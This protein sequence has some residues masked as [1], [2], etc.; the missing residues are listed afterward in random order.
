MTAVRHDDDDDD[1]IVSKDNNGKLDDY[2]GDFIFCAG[3]N[4]H[5]IRRKTETAGD[6]TSS[7]RTCKQLYY[8]HAC[9]G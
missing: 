9:R 5:R 7:Q 4:T 1:D 2:V 6:C 8:A 3:R